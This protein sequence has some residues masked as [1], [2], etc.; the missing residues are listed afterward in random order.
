MRKVMG[1]LAGAVCGAL[2]GAIIAL[3][4]TPASGTEL[5]R[6]AEERWELTLEEAR[7]ARDEKQRE[8]EQQF[9]RAKQL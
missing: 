2:V 8:M 7:K 1:F 3:L 5:I 9:N 6:S 4:F